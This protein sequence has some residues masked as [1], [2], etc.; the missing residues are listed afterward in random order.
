[1]KLHNYANDYALSERL[2]KSTKTTK[3]I[4]KVK[5]AADRIA[6]AEVHN[7]AAEGKPE[8]K[9][10]NKSS[11]PKKAARKTEGEETQEAVQV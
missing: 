9:A 1:M 5:N 10:D 2:R 4:M 7:T 11:A 8:T 3:P 6:G